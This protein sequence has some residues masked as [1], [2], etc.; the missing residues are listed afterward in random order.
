MIKLLLA[1]ALFSQLKNINPDKAVEIEIV[2][3]KKE[4][5]NLLT[6]GEPVT[7]AVEG[8]T[9]LRVYTRIPWPQGTKGNQI[10]KIILQEND[11]DERIVTLESEVS[12][13]TKDALGRPI[14]KWRSFYIKV[15][16]GLNKY[17]IIHWSSVNDTILFK[18]KYESPKKWMDIA[19]MDYNTIIETI[20]EEMVIKYYELQKNG[21]VTLGISGPERLKVITRLNYDEKMLG[22]QNYTILVD[23]NG[24]I[25]KFP[26]KCYKSG[27]IT[28][29]EKQEIVPSNARNFYL[30]LKKGWHDLKFNLAGT[31]AHSVSLRFQVEEK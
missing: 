1:L 24:V 23:D 14:S 15:G 26:L 20:E 31:I 28:Y 2:T 22:E 5:Y 9:Y 27:V 10:Y 13:V 11:V 17:K 30:S 16:E 4:T 25:E 6:K 12:K 19:A 7:F 8:P 18:F 29:K 3:K 21:D